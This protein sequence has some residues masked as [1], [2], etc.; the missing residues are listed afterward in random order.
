MNYNN[1]LAKKETLDQS[2]FTTLSKTAQFFILLRKNGMENLK[3][4]RTRKQL[5]EI[6]KPFI[7]LRVSPHYQSNPQFHQ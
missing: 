2:L 6:S 7:S 1:I 3:L 5:E 4:N